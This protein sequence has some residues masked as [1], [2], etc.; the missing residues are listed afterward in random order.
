M[1]RF[2]QY[3]SLITIVVVSCQKTDNNPDRIYSEGGLISFSTRVETRAPMI[4][5]LNGETFGVYGYKFPNLTNWGTYKAG[6]TPNLFY[7]L[8]VECTEEGVCEYYADSNTALEGQELKE[9]KNVIEGQLLWELSQRYSYFAY[10]PYAALNNVTNYKPSQL[11]DEDN[12]PIYGTPYIEYTLPIAEES[13]V[14]PDN[15]LDVM[16]AKVTDWSPSN[17]TVVRFEFNH[18]LFCIELNGHNF[19]SD[20]VVIS[21]L[22]MKIS[23]IR[24]NTAKIYMDGTLETQPLS[25]D[26]GSYININNV[27]F[28]MI[29]ADERTSISANADVSLT[30]NKLIALIPQTYEPKYEGEVPVGLTI[31]IDFDKIN[32]VNKQE[33]RIPVSREATYNIDF[34]EKLKY[35]LNLNFVGN[36]VILVVA[37]PMTWDSKNIQHTF[38]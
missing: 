20:D 7:N 6:A 34:I 19:N 2:I 32:V 9:G 26:D 14:D 4:T 17:G 37:E 22:S 3:L 31:R 25:A 30:E 13:S 15:M 29:G 11:T 18:R 33:V 35:G 12:N 28:P 24:Y 21:N 5:E 10:Y 23:G 36:D 1:R 27:T 8:P 38:D 16:T